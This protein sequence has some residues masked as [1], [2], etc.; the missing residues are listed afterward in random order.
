MPTFRLLAL[1]IVLASL[2]VTATIFLK[3]AALR[4]SPLLALGGIAFMI[5]VAEVLLYA[6]NAADLTIVS[7]GW[8]VLFQVIIVGVDHVRYHV[9]PGGIQAA[10]IAVALAGLSV[11]ALAPTSGPPVPSTPAAIDPVSL[12]PA[13]VHVDLPQL[14][15]RDAR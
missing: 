3:E 5:A 14:T 8:I 2:D 9:T 10:G 13:Q 11:A 15:A 1:L 4:R 6:V 7:L 12:I